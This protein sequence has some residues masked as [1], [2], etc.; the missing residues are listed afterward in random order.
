MRSLRELDLRVVTVANR[1][2]GVGKT[3]SA[4]TLA[5]GLAKAGEKVLAI[6]G[7]PQG[8]MSLFFSGPA[9]GGEGLSALLGALGSGKPKLESFVKRGVRRNLD[10]LPAGEAELRMTIDGEGLETLASGF[11]A[12][13]E[14]AK[15]RYGW[16]IID[17]SP[18]HGALE[19]LLIGASEALIVPLE[20]QRFSVAGLDALMAE[21]AS[22][23]ERSG[24]QI[25]IQALVFT[26]AENNLAR[27]ESYREVFSNFGVPVFEVCKSEYVPK[28]LE[29]GRTLWE[30]A[31]G[32]YAA[33]DYAAILQKAFVGG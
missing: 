24:R 28:C 10:L 26:K 23:S 4:I 30:S 8:N 11:S 1:K 18:A 12:L 3:V 16:I 32:S 17:S 2:G 14:A 21:V 5:S 20:F 7:D 27:V 22:C 19:R 33:R 13:L 9:K 6:D 15:R 25:R 31:P 29:R